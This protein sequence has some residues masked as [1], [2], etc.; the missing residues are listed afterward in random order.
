MTI[1]LTGASGFVGSHIL[2]HLSAAGHTVL[3]L[4]RRAD[5]DCVADLTDAAA[6]CGALAGAP[7]F[8]MVIHCAAAAHTVAN[9]DDYRRVNA[10]GT[11]NLLAALSARPP[12]HFVLISTIAVYGRQEGLDIT[13]DAPAAATDPYGHSKALAEQMTRQWCTDHDVT[14]TVLRLPLVA[15]PDAPGN[16]GAMQRGLRKGYY[17]HIGR[18]DALRSM[19]HVDDIAPAVMAL[20]AKGGT[21][22]LVATPV[23]LRDFA[24]SLTDRKI[25][26]LPLWAVKTAAAVGNIIP[27][28]PINSARLSKLTASL[29][30]SSEKLHRATDWR[31]R[32]VISKGQ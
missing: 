4:G 29:T 9:D 7:A 16:L 22:N 23:T 15:G 25:H 26:T 31:P 14:L 2:A 30:F 8:D 24:D 20:Y 32:P 6:V 21:Y 11:A 17:M 3:T 19:I 10:D 12:R 18:A 13:E 28:F 5:S 1:L 27:R